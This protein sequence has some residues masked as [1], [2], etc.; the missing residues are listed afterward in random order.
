MRLF[1]D[2]VAMQREYS[3]EAT[4]ASS[5]GNYDQAFAVI[6]QPEHA[7]TFLL[8]F[9][10]GGAVEASYNV[11]AGLGGRRCLQMRV[12]GPAPNRVAF[13]EHRGQC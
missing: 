11:T 7:K 1:P 12:V 6:P 10:R 13:Q 9:G 5:T 8:G 3:N 4:D 2:L